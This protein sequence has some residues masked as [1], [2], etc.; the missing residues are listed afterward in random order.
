MHAKTKPLPTV[1]QMLIHQLPSEEML[2]SPQR[3]LNQCLHSLH[4]TYGETLVGC[5]IGEFMRRINQKYKIDRNNKVKEQIKLT[6]GFARRLNWLAFQLHRAAVAVDD[7][8]EEQLE[9]VAESEQSVH[10]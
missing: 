1:T 2:F 8:A 5:G 4:R 7:C 6:Q 10:Y 3:C 9:S